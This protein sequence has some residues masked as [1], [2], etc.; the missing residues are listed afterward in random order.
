[1]S[2]NISPV[3]IQELLQGRGLGGLFGNLRI[4]MYPTVVNLVLV[5]LPAHTGSWEYHGIIDNISKLLK[6]SGVRK[7]LTSM[8]GMPGIIC[9]SYVNAY[10]YNR[11]EVMPI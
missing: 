11:R 6:S 8:L 2:L 4:Y 7:K 9:S 5:P 3:S 10:F 1:M